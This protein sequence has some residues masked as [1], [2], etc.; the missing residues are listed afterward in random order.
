MSYLAQLAWWGQENG[1]SVPRPISPS[2]PTRD[3]LE[4]AV[5][6]L[7]INGPGQA[8]RTSL[9]FLENPNLD[10][11]EQEDNLVRQLREAAHPEAAAQAVVATAYDLMVSMA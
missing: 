5:G 8:E 10:R 1:A 9:W 3:S 11:E 4:S 2:Q 6:V 7:L